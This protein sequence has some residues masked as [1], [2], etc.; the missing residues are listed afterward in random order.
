MRLTVTTRLVL[1]G[2]GHAH[3]GVLE[4]LIARQRPD[5]DVTLI[6]PAPRTTYSGMLPGW[7]VGQYTLDEIQIDVAALAERANVRFVKDAVVTLDAARRTVVTGGGMRL[8]Y[9]LLSLDVGGAP[10]ASQFAA[11]G[12]RALPVRPL[13]GFVERWREFVACARNAGAGRLAIVGAGAAGV[14]LALAAHGA[15]HSA[16]HGTPVDA[17]RGAWPGAGVPVATRMSG[18]AAPHIDLVDP[19]P[20]LLGGLARGAARRIERL[21]ARRGIVVYRA[22]ATAEPGGLRLDGGTLLDV[23]LAIIATG[24]QPPRWLASSGLALDAAGHVLVRSDYRSVSH[25]SVFAAGDVCARVDRALARSGVHAVKAGPILAHN[26]MAAIDARPLEQYEPRQR[27]LYL[28]NL[29]DRR[30]VM[31]WGGLSA[32]GGWVWR[33]KRTLDRRFV[34][35][36]GAVPG[37]PRR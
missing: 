26:L 22:A 23:D 15:L 24:N 17:V 28:I 33:W 14:E 36:H 9:D 4:A 37:V 8:D 31:S 3:L 13:D 18:R 27:T 7:M 21:L 16:R 1:A 2:G 11:L 32:E 29:G 19:S 12:A 34:R 35:K 20:S 5:L 10:D 6:T 30:A 25:A